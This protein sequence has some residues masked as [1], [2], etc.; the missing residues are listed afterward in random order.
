MSQINLNLTALLLA[1]KEE[2]RQL[3]NRFKQLERERDQFAQMAAEASDL[4]Q[5]LH[6]LR[7][8]NAKLDQ[9]ASKLLDENM[10]IKA[11]NEMLRLPQML[12]PGFYKG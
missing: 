12:A 11:D 10:A 3:Y 7:G 4:R 8:E 9:M 2:K 1:E 6:V 5:Q